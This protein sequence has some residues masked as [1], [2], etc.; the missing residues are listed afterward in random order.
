MKRAALV[1]GLLVLAV[2]LAFSGVR[3]NGFVNYDDPCYIVDN[4]HVRAGLD[5][6]S[7]GWAFTSWECG[8]WHPATWIVHMLDVELLGLDPGAHHLAAV[9]WHA[10]AALALLLVLFRATGDLGPSAFVAF[11]FALHPLHVQSVAW[12]S[13]R[14]DLVSTLLA[15][16]TIGAYVAWTR[17]RG[18]W[19]GAAVVAAYALGLLAKPMLVTLP[20]VLVLLDVWPLGRV[21]LARDLGRLLVEKTPLLALAAVSCVVTILAQRAA[22]AVGTI[23]DLPLRFRLANA[24]T[25]CWAYLG[26]MVWPAGLSF[27]YPFDA[28]IPAVAVALAAAGLLAASV[29]AL[30]VARRAPF[31]TVGWFWYLGTLVPVIGLVQ[32]GAQSRADRYTYLPL[33]GMFIVVAWGGLTLARRLRLPASVTT[34]V[35]SVVVVACGMATRSETPYW[36]DSETLMRRGLAVTV[37]NG[38]AEYYLAKELATSGRDD[39]AVRHYAEAARLLPD[40]ANVLFNFGNAL[41][42]LGRVAEA[43]PLYERA[44]A[45]APSDVENRV[46]LG[47]ALAKAGR[48]DEAVACLTEAVRLAP[49]DAKA[50]YN[51]GVLLAERGDREGAARHFRET[52]RID[53]AHGRARAALDRLPR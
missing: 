43:I 48:I 4:A 27:L 5:A 41:T 13:E 24:A 12:A 16:L 8:N 25:V 32:V 14:K 23:E 20:F 7:L 10:A 38:F 45:L 21:P 28:A 47:T 17:T 3:H 52:L 42:R 26:Q 40:R 46:I 53:P 19:W 30:A 50:H 37:D 29:A 22:G 31:V 11:L 39:E 36:R 9:A 33:V 34:V 2:A 49:D 44:L 15:F 6:S 35:A 18:S 1:S 51:L